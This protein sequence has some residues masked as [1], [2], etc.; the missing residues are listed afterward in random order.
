MTL[1]SKHQKAL[2][3]HLDCSSFFRPTV[4]MTRVTPV[5]LASFPFNVQRVIAQHIT[6]PGSVL[7]ASSFC[8]D[9]IKYHPDMI[10]ST[11]S[12]L[13]LPE[14][15]Q[16]VKIVTANTEI[17]FVCHKMTAWYCEHLRSCQLHYSDAPSMCVV[18]MSQ[19]NDVFPLSAYRVQ[20]QLMVTLR[21][22]V[23]C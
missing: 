3:Y 20:G 2:S 9:G 21:R 4:E 8:V 16:I 5:L 23:I 22:Y 19:L 14:F 1:A 15:A 17:L 12:C 6:M 11:G 18:N 10:G 13:G 7:D